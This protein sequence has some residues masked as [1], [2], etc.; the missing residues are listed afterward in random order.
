MKVVGDENKYLHM[1][2]N[3]G[4]VIRRSLTTSTQSSSTTKQLFTAASTRPLYAKTKSGCCP[5]TTRWVISP[6]RG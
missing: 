6:T 3:S 5:M 2:G 1:C 4:T